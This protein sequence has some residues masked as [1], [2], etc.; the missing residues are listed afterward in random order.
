MDEL[1]DIIKFYNMRRMRTK[2]YREQKNKITKEFKE[3][4]RD[5]VLQNE[6]LKI[7]MTKAYIKGKET[8]SKYYREHRDTILKNSTKRYYNNNNKKIL[9][10]QVK[11]LK[12]NMSLNSENTAND[13]LMKKMDEII[14][15]MR[16]DFVSK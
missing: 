1:D 14:E 15:M 13:D 12:T 11:I 10:K 4:T 9:N 2:K 8:A 3:I 5:D 6:K 7:K 16:I